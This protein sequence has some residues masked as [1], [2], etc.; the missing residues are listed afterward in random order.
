MAVTTTECCAPTN[1]GVVGISSDSAQANESFSRDAHF[2]IDEGLQ[3][4]EPPT[5]IAPAEA[6]EIV[7]E[8]HASWISHNI[9][10]IV[11]QVLEADDAKTRR[12]RGEETMRPHQHA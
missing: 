1:F 7:A 9:G 6:A 8:Q 10:T 11:D 4:V 3:Q 2:T 12:T 5:A